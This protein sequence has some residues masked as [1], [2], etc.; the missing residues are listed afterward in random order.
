M[1]DLVQVGHTN[2]LKKTVLNQGAIINKTAKKI[3]KKFY[4]LTYLLNTFLYIKIA[5]TKA[6]KI[7]KYLYLFVV[8]LRD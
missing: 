4:F 5:I 2:H 7:K 6:D 3:F 8:V 1:L